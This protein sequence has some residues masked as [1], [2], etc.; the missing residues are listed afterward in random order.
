MKK[1]NTLREDSL[2]EKLKASDP[3]GTYIHDFV[4]SDNPKF[5]G[6]SKAK[7]IQM[8]LAASYAAKGK[9]RNEEVEIVYEANIQP[10]SAK[11]RSHIGNLSNP[12]V[13]SVNHSGKEIGLITKQPSGEYH[14]HHSAAKLSHAESGTFDTKDKAHQFIRNAHAK[15]IKSGT[16]SNRFLNKEEVEEG[17]MQ[18]VSKSV[19]KMVRTVAKKASKAL[20]GGTDQDQLDA[21]HKRMGLPPKPKKTMKESELS[22][23]FWDEE[24]EMIISQLRTIVAKSNMIMTKLANDTQLEA[25]V[26]SKVTTAEDSINSVHDYLMYS[27][28]STE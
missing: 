6:K 13:N 14:A 4:H 21:L 5:A 28:D 23:K 24:G 18:D 22:E 12:T 17:V 15:A 11:S 9:S 8:A 3:A 25:W 2:E 7:R 10:T 16:L 1:F 26:Q 19:G 27:K 20:T